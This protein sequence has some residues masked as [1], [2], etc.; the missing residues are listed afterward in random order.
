MLED[1]DKKE[2][3]EFYQDYWKYVKFGF[4][5]YQELVKEIY[6]KFNCVEDVERK[7]QLLADNKTT[8]LQKQNIFKYVPEMNLAYWA[9]EE[10]ISAFGGLKISDI[11][12]VKEGLKTGDN[13]RFI[14]YWTEVDINKTNIKDESGAK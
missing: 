10:M 7:L 13:E 2:A 14:R 1:Y 11:A 8:F 3:Q 9:N 6:A 4:S 12:Y 5:Q